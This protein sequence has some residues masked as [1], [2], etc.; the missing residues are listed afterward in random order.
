MKHILHIFYISI[1]F[2]ILHIFYI[3]TYFQLSVTVLERAAYTSCFISRSH[4]ERYAANQSTF[5]LG[6]S[7][8]PPFL[9]SYFPLLR[10]CLPCRATLPAVRLSAVLGA[11]IRRGCELLTHGAPASD[12]IERQYWSQDEA[13]VNVCQQSGSAPGR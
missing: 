7:T 8:Q 12:V 3:F 4:S 9:S 13:P 2:Y 6:K 1:C 5:P 11:P 10:V